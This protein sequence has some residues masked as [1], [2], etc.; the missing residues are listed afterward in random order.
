MET[1][2][3]EQKL[4]D[5]VVEMALEKS[6]SRSEIQE[7]NELLRKLCLEIVGEVE[8]IHINEV[9]NRIHELKGAELELEK[10]DEVPEVATA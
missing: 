5:L 8:Q 9:I 7:L 3:A 10:R 2:T 4:K 6:Q 1:N